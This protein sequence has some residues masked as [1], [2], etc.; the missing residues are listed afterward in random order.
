MISRLFLLLP[1]IWFIYVWLGFYLDLSVEDSPVFLLWFLMLF[2]GTP[3]TFVIGTVYTY[4]KKR[5]WWFGAYMV[6]GGAPV[7]GYFGLAF[8]DAY[9][10]G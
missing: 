7:L 6:L 3:I 1:L 8:I 4:T 9:F 2:F 5:W 10:S